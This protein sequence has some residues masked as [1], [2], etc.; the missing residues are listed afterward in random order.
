MDQG[1][2]SREQLLKLKKDLQ[3]ALAA[4]EVNKSVQ[5]VKAIQDQGAAVR[6]YPRKSS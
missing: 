3:E 2:Q 1:L 4:G 5:L 6:F